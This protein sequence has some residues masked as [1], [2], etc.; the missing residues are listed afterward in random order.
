MNLKKKR[1]SLLA[2]CMMVILTC[3]FACEWA[4]VTTECTDISLRNIPVDPELEGPWPVG[5]KTVLVDGLVTE[6]W[7]PAVPG[8]EAGKSND[9]I[10]MKQYLPDSDADPNEPQFQV[11]SYKGLPIDTDYG[12]Y[13]V[14][15]YVHGTGSYRHASHGLFT[16]WASRGFVVLC[17]DNPGISFGDLMEGGLAA[18]ATADQKGD[19]QILLDAIRNPS[20][21]LRFLKGAIAN[22]R[23]GL[24]GH[25]A[26]G[27]A[28]GLLGKE[29]G[30]KVI[31]PMA[32]GGVNGTTLESA[33]IM[34]GLEDAA[35]TEPIVRSGYKRT[36]VKKRLVLIPD[37]GH[38]VFLSVCDMILESDTDLGDLTAIAHDGCGPQYMA[39][40]ESIKIVKF[41]STGAFEETL[42]C[43]KTS[44]GQLDTIATKYPG[45]V[46][47]YNE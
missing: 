42:M 6:V 29:D 15:I 35:A 3:V 31:V 44:A 1:L 9:R 19:T 23:Y 10:D 16:H 40:E 45:V 11:N 37:A 8:S 14:I 30:V 13:P 43:S 18:L 22:N 38:N 7:Y 5:S 24:A 46:Y 27:V 36:S 32:S 12:P 2:C 39:P 47:E 20:G 21:E 25:S 28:V 41:A 4:Q 33:M 26:G 34:G 17:C